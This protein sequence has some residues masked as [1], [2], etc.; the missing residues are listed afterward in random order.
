MKRKPALV[1]AAATAVLGSAGLVAVSAVTGANVF[2]FHVGASRP[3]TAGGTNAPTEVPATD[4]EVA[5]DEV[6]LPAIVVMQTEFVD[7]YVTVTT[8]AGRSSTAAAPTPPAGAPAAP[9][10]GSAGTA[11]PAASRSPQAV[12]AAGA[13]GTAAKGTAAPRAATAPTAAPTVVTT[14]VLGSST[15]PASTAF[16]PSKYPF[17]ILMP[18]N[19]GTKFV[20]PLPTPPGGKQWSECELHDKGFW[21]C[22]YP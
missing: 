17:K 9:P 13:P 11:P 10:A 2:G 6:T 16:D 14:A 20:P 7:Q 12:P 3:A 1:I 4:D 21:E 5:A 22:Q 8:R 19:W 18:S 15:T